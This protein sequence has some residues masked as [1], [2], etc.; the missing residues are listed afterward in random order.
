MLGL[1]LGLTTTGWAYLGGEGEIRV[2]ESGTLRPGGRRDGERLA[3][4]REMV[5][6][7]VDRY[8]P[9]EVALEDYILGQ[10]RRN[11]RTLA[12]SAELGGVVKA[13]LAAYAVPVRL[14]GPSAWR[15]QVFGR[16]MKKEE[17]VE[18]AGRRWGWEARWADEVEAMCIAR[19]SW[20]R[21]AP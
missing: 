12:S 14:W 11:P 2:V 8:K 5:D 4:F 6:E 17:V 20:E 13:I 16:D 19:A 10:A 15:K 1:D 21:G 9:G 7:V 18:E 3:W